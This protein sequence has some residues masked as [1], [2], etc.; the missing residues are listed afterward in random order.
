MLSIGI[1][2]SGAMA[3]YHASRYSA[4][5]GVRV[6]A[7]CDRQP[8]RAEAFAIAHGIPRHF[9]G[10][11]EMAASGAVQAFSV[12]SSDGWHL[13]P[14][15]AA[16]SR[17][18]PV[19]C[20]KP[21]ARNLGDAGTMARAATASGIPAMVNFSK[22][23]GGLLSTARRLLREGRVGTPR[24]ASLSYLQSW[25]VQDSWGD[26]RTGPR[27]RWRLREDSSTFGA[28]GD[29]GSH[30]I[31]AALFLLG[32][33]G[34]A[35]CLGTRFSPAPEGEEPAWESFT[36][37]LD[38][39]GAAVALEAGFRAP[40]HLDRFALSLRGTLASIEIDLAA[41]RKSLR[42][43]GPGIGEVE[44]VAADPRPSTYERFVAL[45]AGGTDPVAEE[46]PGFAQGLGV[47][48]L[49]EACAILAL[50]A[51]TG[52]VGRNHG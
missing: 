5:P 7:C 37:L 3:E 21:L 4:L 30:L 46:E 29:L 24:G 38:Q 25:L 28:L 52:R 23:N 40:G 33:A 10:P 49:I 50:A 43:L 11:G 14:V 39:G 17:G 13:E 45:A 16:L 1:V 18:L 12:A 44:E 9:P 2:G 35:A 51:E 48:E 34:A 20:E 6:A 8:G 32:P 26:W 27:W 41:S 42:V 22:R 47:Q 15:M 36:A 19:L 31:D